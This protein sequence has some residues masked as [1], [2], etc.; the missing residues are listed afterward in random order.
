MLGPDVVVIQPPRLVDRELNHLLRSRSQT[1][2]TQHGAIA[3]S[4]DEFNS[5]SNLS[6]LHAQVGQ[7]L[8]RH[9]VALA[10]QTEQQMLGAD[11]VV[12]EALSFFLRQRQ[13]APRAFSELVKSICHGSLQCTMRPQRSRSRN[14]A[15][16]S[17]H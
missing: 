12:V 3:A 4:D 16:L 15:S 8:R 14:T 9:P 1:N 7:H 17:E 5:R 11:V 13:D 2:L 10:H 6:Q